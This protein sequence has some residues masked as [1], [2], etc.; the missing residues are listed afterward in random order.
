MSE[1]KA[2]PNKI[3]YQF[4]PVPK[5]FMTN[6]FLEDPCMMK[7]ILFIMKRI[8]TSS[9]IFKFKSNGIHEIKLEPFEFVFGR[10][11]CAKETGLTHRQIR[12]RINK[13]ATSSSTSSSTSSF[14]VYKLLTSDFIENGDQQNDQQNDHKQETREQEVVSLSKKETRKKKD[15]YNSVTPQPPKGGVVVP[16]SLL[17]NEKTKETALLEDIVVLEGVL[18]DHLSIINPSPKTIRIW[19]EKYGL[20]R[21]VD[22]IKLLKKKPALVPNKMGWLRSCLDNK[23]DIQEKN[24]VVNREFFIKYK[25]Y[26]NLNNLQI[27]GTMAK[28]K[29]NDYE[30]DFKRDPEDL[31]QYVKEKYVG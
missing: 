3:P 7:L 1:D 14:S 23:W 5:E 19:I 27:Y 30:F 9:H 28:D 11:A 4:Y 18:S 2:N 20:D 21:V 6:E 8:R 22:S 31:Q 26:M 17:N 16:L 24:L 12:S 29:N 10:D 25:E 15:V 13:I